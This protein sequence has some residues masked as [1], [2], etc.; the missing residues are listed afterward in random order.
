[1]NLVNY[2][3]TLIPSFKK[4]AVLESCELTKQSLSEH[5]L[6]AFEQATDHFKNTGF[7]NKQLLDLVKE[8]SKNVTKT[9]DKS[10]ISSIKDNLT[11][12]VNLLETVET[13]AKNDISTTEA[14]LALTYKKSMLLRLIQTSEFLSV[15]SRKLL[16]YIYIVESQEYEYG[17]SLKNTLSKMEIEFVENNFYNFTIACKVISDANKTFQKS[18]KEIPEAVIS[19]L[20]EITLPETLGAH[21]LDPFLMNGFVDVSVVWNPFYLVGMMVAEWQANNFKKNQNELTMLQLRLF[22]LQKISS[23]EP[24]A[25]LQKEIE[26]LQDRITNIDYKIHKMKE[27]YNV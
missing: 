4:D 5:T 22:N 10:F 13:T 8:Y 2:I 17:T 12:A 24:D 11:D 26:H 7:K 19:D 14:S 21:K 1:M 9:T 20:S 15:Y 27:N 23:G 16:N 25:A 18:Y 3:K 6:P